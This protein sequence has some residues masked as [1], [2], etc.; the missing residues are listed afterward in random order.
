MTH[1][2]AVL[3]NRVFI[4]R[5]GRTQHCLP[6]FETPAVTLTASC[7]ST[8]KAYFSHS[9]LDATSNFFP[10][11]LFEASCKR[12]GVGGLRLL[13]IAG[14]VYGCVTMVSPRC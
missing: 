2:R 5:T 7:L 12:R 6:S 9:Q 8:S 13:L 10:V 1:F 3:L 11:G 14:C 4:V